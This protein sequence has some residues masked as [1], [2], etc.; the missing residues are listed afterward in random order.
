MTTLFFIQCIATIIQSSYFIHNK[1]FL[2]KLPTYI[3][4]ELINTT[5]RRNPYIVDLVLNYIEFVNF[6][7]TLALFKLHYF[8]Q[9]S[10]ST[11]PVPAM[12]AF[13][14]TLGD[15]FSVS[16]PSECLECLPSEAFSV[17]YIQKYSGGHLETI[18]Y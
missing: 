9:C 2:N 3:L 17:C 5:C 4:Y 1:L 7:I 6:L 15:G 12:M 8:R 10:E 11:E 14:V 16:L 18:I 13:R